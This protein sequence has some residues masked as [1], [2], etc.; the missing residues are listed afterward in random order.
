MYYY[1]A[2]MAKRLTTV[3]WNVFLF[4]FRTPFH[5]LRTDQ[6]FKNF[7]HSVQKRVLPS[8]LEDP[9]LPGE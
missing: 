2:L 9:T 7:E 1:I 4:K 5:D 8:S 6:D 3:E